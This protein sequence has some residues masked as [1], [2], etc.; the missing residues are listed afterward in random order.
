VIAVF[1]LR[2][3]IPV[4]A[5]LVLGLAL[6][7]FVATFA[8][9]YGGGVPGTV[10]E[11]V[12]SL[13]LTVPVKVAET[14]H[15]SL[16]RHAILPFAYVAALAGEL[17]P[18][19]G[20]LYL[21]RKRHRAQIAR[22]TLCLCTMVTGVMIAS[23][24]HQVGYSEIYF[25]D[26]A[27]GA[28]FVVAAGG[29]YLAWTDVR[30][31]GAGSTRAVLVAFV[32]CIALILAISAVTSPAPT[33]GGVTV[34]YVAIALASVAFVTIV[35]LFATRRQLRSPGGL[36]VGLIPLIAA[37]ALGSP[38]QLSP[39]IGRVLTGRP[40]TITQPD[41][42]VVRGLTPGLLLALQWL[43]NHTS[44][45][46]VFAVSNHWINAAGTDGRDQY[47]SGFSERR[48]FVE[49]YN[50]DDYGITVGVS[51]PAEVNFLYRVQLNDAVFEHASAGALA[52][53]THQYG[54][55]YLFIDRIHG[56]AAAAV[57]GLGAVVFSDSDATIVAVG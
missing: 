7:V 44:V 13:K 50:P 23:L 4:N 9:I 12:A 51:A 56:G 47:Y 6:V 41:P 31:T 25:Q 34:R 22:Y 29:L 15:H 3:T 52:I 14:I 42:Q 37:S 35:V 2:R 48:V 38:I 20:A 21:L 30:S 26:T 8:V 18:F 24:F 27:Y 36:L 54:V 39:I 11:P 49:S 10:V 16:L 53:L 55:R 5:L 19:A 46:T 43:Q 40:I 1:A 45:N 33:L 17:L 57:L 28:G 32:G